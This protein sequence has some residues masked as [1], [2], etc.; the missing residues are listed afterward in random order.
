MPK[1]IIGFAALALLIATFMSASRPGAVEI[2]A[3]RATSLAGSEEVPPADPDGSGF[4]TLRLNQGQRTVSWEL[5]VE[6]IEPATAAH[7]HHAPSGMNGPVVVTLSPPTD[8]RSSGTADNVDRALIKDI[9]QHSDQY[10]VNVHNATYPNGAIRGQ[11]TNR[12]PSD[13]LGTR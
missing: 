2:G 10:Y 11:L 3:T 4:V 13:S 12:G 5:T 8:G 7:V 1:S 9:I 6:N